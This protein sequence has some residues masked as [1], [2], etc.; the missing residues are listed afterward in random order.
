[1]PLTNPGY[2]G[3]PIPA[4]KELQGLQVSLVA[5]GDAEA[6]TAVPG[7]T[8]SAVVLSALDNDAGTITDVTDTISVDPGKSSGTLTL[9]TTV[10]DETAT[11][12]DVVFTFKASPAAAYNSVQLGEDDTESAANLAAAINAYFGQPSMIQQY[13][14]V[15]ATS[16]AAVVTV[17][18]RTP[19]TAA[20][21]IALAGDTTITASG[22]TLENGA[23]SAGVASSGATNQ[24]IL[25]WYNK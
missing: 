13:M 6:V 11:V 15:E 16:D 1:M 8:G 18:A 17:T 22:A 7:M 12:H 25:F 2:A 20:N 24:L 23:A 3:D 21:A 10:A 9:D 19:G 5:G 4:I 14:G